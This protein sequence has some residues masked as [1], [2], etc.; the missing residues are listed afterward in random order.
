LIGVGRK[1]DLLRGGRITPLAIKAAS[2]A[3]IVADTIVTTGFPRRVT[4][5]GSPA[6]A[7][8]MIRLALFFSSRMPTVFA[9]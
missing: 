2:S 3:G 5:I 8:S 9:M 6:S 4:V 7:C 1:R